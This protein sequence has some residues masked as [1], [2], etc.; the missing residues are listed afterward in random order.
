MA[1]VKD[2]IG[3]RFWRIKA[4]NHVRPASVF[5]LQLPAPAVVASILRRVRPLVCKSLVILLSLAYDKPRTG[6]WSYSTSYSAAIFVS[7]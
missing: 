7:A 3:N 5:D 4:A 6:S 2:T 1:H